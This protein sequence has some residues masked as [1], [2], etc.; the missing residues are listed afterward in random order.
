MNRCQRRGGV[1]S[2]PES[3][4]RPG[5]PRKIGFTYSEGLQRRRQFADAVTAQLVG[6]VD[7]EVRISLVDDLAFFA[8]SAGDNMH[9]GAGSGVMRNGST[10]CQ[11][12][13]VRMR[14]NEKQTGRFL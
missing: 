13:I 10:G 6:V 3:R 9:V 2:I 14:M 11:R 12:F 7:S 1:P 8:E 5:P 4:H